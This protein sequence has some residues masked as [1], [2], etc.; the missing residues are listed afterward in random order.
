MD[1]FGDR[2]RPV[3]ELQLS[4]ATVAAGEELE[5]VTA[6]LVEALAPLAAPLS[7]SPPP[8]GPSA[9]VRVSGRKVAST[10]GR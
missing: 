7:P 8:F 10:S 1:G 5:F 3:S 4:P 2:R 6:E 9:R